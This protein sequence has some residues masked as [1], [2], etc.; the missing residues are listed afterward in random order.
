MRSPRAKS[1]KVTDADRAEHAFLFDAHFALSTFHWQV[2]KTDGR[3][4]LVMMEALR[5]PPASLN[6]GED[7]A[8]FKSL[9]GTLIKCPG[10]GQCANP[11]FCKAGFFQV[12]VPESAVQTPASELP[13]WIDPERYT[14][15]AC[16]LRISRKTHADD[17]PSTFSC[18]LQWKARRAEIEVLARQAESLADTAKRIPVLADTT[19]VRSFDAVLNSLLAQHQPGVS[20]CASRRF[21]SIKADKLFHHLHRRC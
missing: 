12:K 6:N 1:S 10:P 14:P 16:P 19:L 11:L 21:G 18:R 5:C 20:L 8:V 2:L 13:H 4:T 15:I 7:N 3:K 17:A 9:I